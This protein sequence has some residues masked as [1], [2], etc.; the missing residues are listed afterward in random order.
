MLNAVSGLSIGTLVLK[1]H[2][3]MGGL[4]IKDPLSLSWDMLIRQ[5]KTS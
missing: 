5:Y 4:F 2:K 1:D 3:P